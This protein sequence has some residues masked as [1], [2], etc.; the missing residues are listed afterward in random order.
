MLSPKFRGSHYCGCGDIWWA[1]DRC[2]VAQLNPLSRVFPTAFC[3]LP[4]TGLSP[5]CHN[6]STLELVE[7][8]L[9]HAN[10]VVKL[11]SIVGCG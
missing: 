4:S 5:R 10:L 1:V 2:G 7:L 3:P 9:G 6:V 11:K 8:G